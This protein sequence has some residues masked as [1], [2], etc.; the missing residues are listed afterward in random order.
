MLVRFVFKD[1]LVVLDS[2]RLTGD[3][4]TRLTPGLP[5]SLLASAWIGRPLLILGLLL[6]G[7]DG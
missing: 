3:H 7:G 1:S 4:G 2:E 6:S 5:A